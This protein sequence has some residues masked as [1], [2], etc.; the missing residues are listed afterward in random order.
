MSGEV[1]PEF[2]AVAAWKVADRAAARVTVA[3]HSWVRP[4]GPW[5]HAIYE[6]ALIG[7]A[8]ES[9]AAVLEARQAT[10]EIRSTP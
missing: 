8:V 4:A 1:G 7:A 10:A 2:Y 9:L 6:Q 5:L 3:A